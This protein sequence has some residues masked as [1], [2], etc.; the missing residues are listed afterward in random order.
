MPNPNEEREESALVRGRILEELYDKARLERGNDEDIS[1]YLDEALLYSRVGRRFPQFLRQLR[2]ELFYLR[3]R[4]YVK[5]REVK[6]G[7]KK[8]LL[9]RITA[10]GIDLLQGVKE[11]SGVHVE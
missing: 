6:T 2:I 3:D 8:S 10:D 4:G 1:T 9:W 5:F 11:D 7:R